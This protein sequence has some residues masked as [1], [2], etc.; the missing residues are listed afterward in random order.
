M[1]VLLSHIRK[2]QNLVTPYPTSSCLQNK[3]TVRGKGGRP[4]LLHTQV[5]KGGDFLCHPFVL[6]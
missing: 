4:F 2:G 5:T 6:Y 1:D 3:A